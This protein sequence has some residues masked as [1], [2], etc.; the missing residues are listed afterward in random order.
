MTEYRTGLGWDVHR[1]GPNRPLMVGGVQV[2]LPVTPVPKSIRAL[3]T[4]A[5]PPNATVLL[6]PPASVTVK[7]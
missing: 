5:G 3:P 4:L 1:T 6:P 7:A 2:L